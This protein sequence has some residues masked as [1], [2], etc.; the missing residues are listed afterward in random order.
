M[1]DLAGKVILVTGASRGIGAAIASRVAADG[2][3][4]VLHYGAS[5]ARAEALT[6]EIGPG[7]CL[8]VGADLADD[9]AVAGLWRRAVAWRGRVD[10]LVNN[11]GIYEPCPLDAEFAVWAEA[12][13]RTTQ[14]NLFASAHLSREAIRHFRATGGGILISI[15]SRAAFRG[16]A[17]EY[18][19]YGASKGAMV[20]MMRGLARA[21]ARDGVLCYVVAPGFVRTEMAEDFVRRYGEAAAVGD[22][23]Q[24][25]MASP[26]TIANVAAFLASGRA[27]H[28]TG[29][30]IDVNGASYM[31]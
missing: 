27:R 6:R 18:I 10:V 8:A 3:S 12:W 20:A 9:A 29:A 22:I 23:P 19:H 16:D 15:A 11:A 25:E 30:T 5:R 17:A 4:V 13:R 28:A 14:V 26:E 21:F 24:G 7:R 2:A 31:H 1:A